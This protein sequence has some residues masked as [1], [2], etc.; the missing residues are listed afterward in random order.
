[1]TGAEQLQVAIYNLL[2]AEEYAV[3]SKLPAAGTAYPFIFL[4][5][6]Y[7]TDP[8]L[9]K[10]GNHYEMYRVI[11]TFSNSPNKAE[12]LAMNEKVISLMRGPITLS[13]GYTIERAILD[14]AQT[15]LDPDEDSVW[16]GNLRFTFIL[17]G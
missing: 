7:I 12:I 1:M 8:V 15:M 10:E 6:E 16:H 2:K 4:G 13:G 17:K 14:F 3:Y 11:H 9:S 5:E